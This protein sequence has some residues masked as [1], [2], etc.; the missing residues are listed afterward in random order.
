MGK[1]HSCICLVS[2]PRNCKFSPGPI[3]NSSTTPTIIPHLFLFLSSLLQ[4][5]HS[6]H[7]TSPHLIPTSPHPHLLF[8]YSVALSHFSILPNPSSM[9]PLYRY[10]KSL[11][12]LTPDPFLFFPSLRAFSGMY[13]KC[14]HGVPGMVL[15][16]SSFPLQV[17]LG[18]FGYR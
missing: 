4:P 7:L 5:S 2:T 11:I 9:F 1:H 12:F 16:L 6:P 15:F 10:C 13:S 8:R 17:V 18:L 14:L 3:V